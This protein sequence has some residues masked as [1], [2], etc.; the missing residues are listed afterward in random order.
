MDTQRKLRGMLAGGALC[1]LGALPAAAPA[2]TVTAAECGEGADF[3]RNAARSRDNGMTAFDF[4]GRLESDL[5]AIRAYPAAMRWFAK[6]EDDERLLRLAAASVFE[7][8]RPAPE[9]HDAFLASCSALVAVQSG[10]S[11]DRGG[12]LRR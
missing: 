4:L 9:H 11:A 6:D 7:R 12:P 10:P 1:V 3:I 8:P 5:V 2:L